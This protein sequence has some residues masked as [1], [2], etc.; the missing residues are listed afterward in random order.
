MPVVECC[1][2]QKIALWHLASTVDIID[3][4]KEKSAMT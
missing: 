3:C 4:L 1:A 2:K